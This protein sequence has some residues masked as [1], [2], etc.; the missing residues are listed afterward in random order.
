MLISGATG[1]LLQFPLYFGILGI[2]VGS[3]LILDISDA[4]V[5]ISNEHTFPIFTFFSADLVNIF[6]PSGGGQWAVQGPVIIASSSR[7]WCFLS[8]SNYG[9]CLW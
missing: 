1:I 5:S 8:E 4:F 2:M 6:V 7:T 9:P 3:G